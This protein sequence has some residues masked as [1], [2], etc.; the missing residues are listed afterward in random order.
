MIVQLFTVSF[1]SKVGQQTSELFYS[2]F[3]HRIPI[4]QIADIVKY[5]C[6]A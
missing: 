4:I 6:L 5:I 3:N 2:Y 1:Y